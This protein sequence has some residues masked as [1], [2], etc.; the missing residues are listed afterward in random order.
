MAG[1]EQK[2]PPSYVDAIK[3]T[4][5][6][7]KA[8]PNPDALLVAAQ[9]LSGD[10]GPGGLT[11]SPPSVGSPVLPLG[12]DPLSTGPLSGCPTPAVVIG[13]T[14]A[15]PIIALAP[16]V[17]A[18]ATTSRP[19]FSELL[20]A[21]EARDKDK[22][23]SLPVSELATVCEE[24][25]VC[26]QS[27]FDRVMSR[28]N[29]LQNGWLGYDEFAQNLYS[30]LRASKSAAATESPGAPAAHVNMDELMG[31]VAM[32]PDLD[33]EIV[34]RVLQS[35][36]CVEAAVDALL[37]LSTSRT[38]PADLLPLA[39][40]PEQSS[41]PAPMPPPV[42]PSP[43][44][45]RASWNGQSDATCCWRCMSTDRAEHGIACEERAPADVLTRLA[46]MFP[47]LDREVVALALEQAGTWSGCGGHNELAAMEAVVDALLN[48]S[49]DASESTGIESRTDAE[50][51]VE[52]EG[53]YKDFF[54]ARADC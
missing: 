43:S 54:R 11:Y 37:T 7:A 48:V 36:E 16:T 38:T 25:R 1:F 49:N 27:I 2:P 20:R 5:R 3:D 50:L 31:L 23:G 46:A 52:L 33:R 26:D 4:L 44:C 40:L 19:Y 6:L 34:A 18:V 14:V 15:L 42:C 51:H 41:R 28:C 24:L 17:A 13:D 47:D 32:F 39:D 29:S 8:A 10:W 35:Q 21:F 9:K 12:S 45:G 22:S 53:L 30:H